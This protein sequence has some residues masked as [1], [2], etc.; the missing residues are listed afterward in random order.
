VRNCFDDVT[1]REY[2]TTSVRYTL[3]SL[4][5]RLPDVARLR[6]LAWLAAQYQLATDLSQ[7][8]S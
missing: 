3:R 7:L 6:L 4:G 8:K 5:F 2:L 1:L